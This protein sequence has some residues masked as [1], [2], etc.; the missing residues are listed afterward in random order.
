MSRKKQKR[1]KNQDRVLKNVLHGTSFCGLLMSV[2]AANAADISTSVTIS[3]ADTNAA[4]LNQS[5]TV[6]EGGSLTFTNYVPNQTEAITVTNH[7]TLTF[8]VTEGTQ[9]LVKNSALLTLNGSQ[10]FIKTGGG[11]LQALNADNRVKFAYDSGAQIQILEGTFRNGEWLQQDWTENKADMLLN[12]TLDLWDGGRTNSAGVMIDVLSGTGKVTAGAGSDPGLFVLGVDNG[13]GTFAGTIVG[14]PAASRSISIEKRGT[15]TQIFTGQNTYSGTTKISGGTLQ[16]GDGGTTGSL[17]TGNVTVENGAA[18]AFN[19]ASGYIH[20]TNTSIANSGTVSIQGGFVTLP[21]LTNSDSGTVSVN[22]GAGFTV[23]NRTVMETVS[24]EDGGILLLRASESDTTAWTTAQIAA[25]RAKTSPIYGAYA[26]ADTTITADALLTGNGRLYLGGD[27]RFEFTAANTDFTNGVTLLS[28]TAAMTG[29]AAMNASNTVTVNSQ[30]A[31]AYDLG[32]GTTTDVTNAISGDGTLAIQSGTVRFTASSPK[33]G[34]AYVQVANVRVADGAVLL[35]TDAVAPRP[36]ITSTITA[37]TGGKVR[38]ESTSYSD[39]GHQN[40]HSLANTATGHVILAGTGTFEFGGGGTTAILPG[41]DYAR[42]SISLAKGGWL[43]VADGSNLVLGGYSYH[44]SWTDNY[45]S[46]NIEEAASRVSLWDG[47][48]ITIDSLTG[49]GIIESGAVKLGIGNNENSA[50]YGVANNTAEFAGVIRDNTVNS[51][52]RAASITKVGTGTQI[53]SGANTYTGKTTVSNGTLQIGNGGENGSLGTGAVEVQHAATLQFDRSAESTLRADANLFGT[54]RNMKSTLNVGSADAPLTFQP[55]GQKF[56]AD[57]DAKIRF[58]LADAVQKTNARFTGDGTIEFSR[59]TVLDA[60]DAIFTMGENGVTVFDGGSV[61][62]PIYSDFG[63]LTVTND[64]VWNI[65]VHEGTWSK[66]VY[67]NADGNIKPTTAYTSSKYLGEGKNVDDL[68]NNTSNSSVRANGLGNNSAASY[69]TYITVTEETILDLTGGYDDYA[70][71]FAMK[72]TDENGIVLESPE[73]QTLLDFGGKCARVTASGVVLSPG[74]YLLD[75]RVADVGGDAYANNGAILDPTGKRLGLGIRLTGGALTGDTYYSLTIGDD[76]FIGDPSLGLTLE[77][78]R[79]LAAGTRAFNIAEG[80]TLTIR[81]PAPAG[82]VTMTANVTGTGTLA[83]ENTSGANS[84]YAL[85]GSS[86]GSLYAGDNIT[87]K[88][89]KDTRFELTGDYSQGDVDFLIDL[90]GITEDT[91]WFTEVSGTE[92]LTE[93]TTFTFTTSD[94]EMLPVELTFFAGTGLTD[95]QWAKMVDL[96]QVS[97]I[98]N[99]GNLFVDERG[100]L[101]VTVG[102]VTSL[103]EPSAYVLLGCG[104]ALLALMRREKRK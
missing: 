78:Q 95:E 94:T 10:G 51:N 27:G 52:L 63:T 65:A 44:I 38:F 84:V 26:S 37:E 86:A 11:I 89:S 55:Q 62:A 41:S 34:E 97:G 46:L 23:L 45:G 93:N 72:I 50:A 53:F 43:N 73:W 67:S 15:G 87:M 48:E 18:L 56:I 74:Y 82:S 3:S 14:A 104:L 92:G 20:S 24:A 29:N 4:Y 75:A 59:N 99:A 33:S 69:R 31:F 8:N 90:T 54:L 64:T 16:I 28:G 9:T 2:L 36:S 100:T 61:T 91:G 68:I 60:S 88:L 40:N 47:N 35:F 66:T 12:G 79:E 49:F 30:A 58:H 80:K 5:L 85:S 42:A 7:G 98:L 101:H 32:A 19:F 77:T 1:Q 76:G 81:N 39:I 102:D 6:L 21:N 13:S 83:L 71:I 103:P 25:E 70:G 57:S 17:G 96:S 22:S